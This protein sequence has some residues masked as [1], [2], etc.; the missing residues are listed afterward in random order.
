MLKGRVI[1]SGTAEGEALVASHPISF[2]GGVN[3]ESGEIIERGHELQGES[4]SGRILVFP[5]GKGSTV[6]SYILYR[7]MKK[8]LAPAAII[9]EKCE[10]IVAVG[11]II[12]GIPCVDMVD[13]A[14][15]RQGSRLRISGAR[16]WLQKDQL[17]EFRNRAYIGHSDRKNRRRDYERVD[18]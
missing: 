3:P 7:L 16:V 8:G 9:N 12:S 2:Y 14:K 5:Y 1:Y 15:I 17:S 13:I 10:T 6:G 18:R 11:A 4:V